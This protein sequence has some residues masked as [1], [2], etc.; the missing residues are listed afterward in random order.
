MKKQEIRKKYLE[1]RKQLGP[2]ERTLMSRRIAGFFFDQIYN[3]NFGHIH[4]F[5]PIN[6][7]NEV[8]T[9]VFVEEIKAK[10]LPVKIVISRSDL[11]SGQMTNYLLN[12]Q[13]RLVE[14]KWGVPE[15]ETG[16][17]CDNLL[18]DMVLV[19]LLAFDMKGHR[20][21]Y[22]KGFYDRFL[23][24]CRKD[25]LKVGLSYEGPVGLIEDSGENDVALDCA[26]TPEKIHWFKK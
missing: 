5:L 22:G 23:R 16:E 14:N 4:L 15:P 12:S 21:G 8:D 19:P 25:A 6:K 7:F 10:E 17:L 3:E 20:I 2:E 26:I 9:W 1:K 24:T 13:T 18:I 11:E